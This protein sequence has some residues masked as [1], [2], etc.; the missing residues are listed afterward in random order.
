MHFHGTDPLKFLNNIES[1]WLLRESIGELVD[2]S[3]EPYDNHLTWI[4][5]IQ[6]DIAR[7]HAE[8]FA[9][10]GYEI[11]TEQILVFRDKILGVFLRSWLRQQ[12][13]EP[14]FIGNFKKLVLA[15]FDEITTLLVEKENSQ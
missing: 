9:E 15:G 11:T 8:F 10:P 13:L 7:A 6:S 4:C 2:K 5:A 3:T 1:M 14:M 12:T